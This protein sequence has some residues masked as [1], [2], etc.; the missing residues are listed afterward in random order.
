MKVADEL[1]P[2]R[3]VCAGAG[4]VFLA[5]AILGVGCTAH[6]P[7]LR[8]ASGDGVAVDGVAVGVAPLTTSLRLTAAQY[9]ATVHDLFAPIAIP[10]QVLPAEAAVDGFDNNALVQTPSATL[11]ETYRTSALAITTAAMKAPASLLGCAPR[12]PAE[13]DAC[14]RAFLRIFAT[15]AYRHPATSGELQ[16]LLA[17]YS[18]AR[19][20]GLDFRAAMSLAIEAILQSPTFLYRLEVGTAA[21]GRPGLR[22]LTPYEIAS[23]LSYLLWNTMPD[24][25]LF[26]AAQSGQLATP[27]GVEA[28]ARRLLNDPRAHAAILRFHSQWL[29]FNKMDNLVKSGAMFPAFNDGVAAAMRQSAEKYV[30]D[31]FFGEGTLTA[32]LTDHHAWVNDVLAPVYGVKAPGGS[33]LVR[34]SLDPTQRSGILTNAGLLAGFAHETA[35]SPVLRGVFVLDRLLCGAPPPPPARV[36]TTP[37]AENPSSPTTTR[38]RFATQ[39][40]Q[41]SC[42][43]CHRAIDGIG[44]GFEHYD[45][46]GQW[47]TSDSGIAVDASGWFTPGSGDLDG[48]FDGAVELGQ[49]L[50]R[51][52]SVH[53][54]VAS[55]WMRYAL[56]TDRADVDPAALAPIVA[57]FEQSGLHLRELVIALVKSDAFRTR[58]T[59]I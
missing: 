37:P 59:G 26:A 24:A 6:S 7:H 53:A 40:E 36:N 44:F 17:F 30:D 19:G 18:S 22:Q 11:I 1:E 49:K 54:C 58:A 52:R 10:D 3:P 55:E 56:G 33:A 12:A 13:E 25:A 34:V 15:K 32:L 41:A 46:L 47:R 35:D 31:I 45:A 14:A 51:S 29:R 4:L 2:S 48:V 9:N 50:A 27:A 39:H 20:G 8:S 23:R 5:T 43:G 42:A 16:S 57:A 38:Q 28:Q 21:P